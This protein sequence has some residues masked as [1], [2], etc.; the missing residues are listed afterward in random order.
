MAGQATILVE[1]SIPGTMGR[2][3]PLRPGLCSSLDSLGKALP[4]TLARAVA[5]FGLVF[6]S[7]FCALS[8]IGLSAGTVKV[9][10]LPSRML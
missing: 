1:L 4:A 8:F 9:G 5:V 2:R 10:Y 6:S 3:S 7:V